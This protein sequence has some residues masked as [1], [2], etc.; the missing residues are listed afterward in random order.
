MQTTAPNTP[1]HTV[2]AKFIPGISMEGDLVDIEQVKFDLWERS[3]VF[4]NDDFG[5]LVKCEAHGCKSY[6]HVTCVSMH[7]NKRRIILDI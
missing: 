2:C 6:M 1:I 3:C 7:S 5:I 4:C